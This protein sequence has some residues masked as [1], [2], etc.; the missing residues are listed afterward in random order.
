MRE[1]YIG[2]AEPKCVKCGKNQFELLRTGNFQI[3][4][5]CIHCREPQVLD[6]VDKN[7]QW[8]E[9]LRFWSSGTEEN[10]E[11]EK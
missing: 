11:S 3:T 6:A 4:A 8:P 5:V 1:N 10:V 9:I 7:T 2:E